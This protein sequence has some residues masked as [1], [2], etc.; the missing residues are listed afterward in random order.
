MLIST[1]DIVPIPLAYPSPT[2]TVFST[3]GE[4][5]SAKRI[6]ADLNAEATNAEKASQRLQR[7][8]LDVKHLLKPEDLPQYKFKIPSR[9]ASRFSTQSDGQATAATPLPKPKL[10]AF[11]EMVLNNTDVSYHYPSPVSG[12]SDSDSP[13]RTSSS[14]S[15]QKPHTPQAAPGAAPQAS[16]S[17]TLVSHGQYAQTLQPSP[18][19]RKIIKTP[20]V[21]IPRG[22]NATER[23]QYQ[24]YPEVALPY[25]ADAESPSKKR[26]KDTT[27][28]TE[29]ELRASV[30]QNQKANAALTKLST[31]LADIFEAEDQLQPDTS[32]LVSQNTATIFVSD[33][34]ENPVLRP[35]I[36]SQLDTLLK[37][38]AA[39]Q[40][41]GNVE[42][43][44]LSRIQKLCLNAV[45]PAATVSLGVG[46]DWSDS[47]VE[48]WCHRLTIAE[49]G[50]HACTSLLRVMTAGRQEKELYSE[51]MLRT[52]VEMITHVVDTCI[53]PI[54]EMRSTSE[55]FKQASSQSKI[56]SSIFSSMTKVLKLL[57]GLFA[58]MD[59][60]ESAVTSSEFICKTLL[61]GETPTSEKDSVVAGQ[62]FEPV[63]RAAMDVMARIF[64]RYTDQRQFIF[65]EIL[66]SLE[67]LPV[68][69]Q[70][71]RLFKLI[72]SKPIQPASALLMRLVQTSAVYTPA[73]NAAKSYGGARDGEEGSG[74]DADSDSEDDKRYIP[75][76]KGPSAPNASNEDLGTIA[77]PLQQAAQKNAQY[78]VQYLVG[79][80]LTSKKSGDE[81]Y[82]NLLDIFT[83]DFLT[84]LG[85]P[86]WPAAELLLRALFLK[87]S[88]IVDSKQNTVPAKVMALELLGAIASGIMDLQ[89]HAQRLGQAAGK[90]HSDVTARLV[91]L[92]D[93]ILTGDVSE[94]DLLGFEGPYR[95]V[96]EYLDR[97]DTNAADAHLRTAR[98]YHTM[99]WAVEAVPKRA[100]S[101]NS[102][103]DKLDKSLE[104]C[105]SKM[106]RDPRWLETEYDFAQV[107]PEDGRLAS[108]LIT[109]HP[110]MSYVLR[111]VFTRLVQT[112]TDEQASIRSKSLKSVEHL[113][114]KD[115]A[116]LDR[117]ASILTAITRST[118]DTSPRVRDSAYGL[119]AK[120]LSLRPSLDLRVYEALAARADD[121]NVGIRK[122]LMKMLKEI[123]ARNSTEQVRTRVAEALIH[124]IA[125]VEESV[126]D[127][128]RQSFEE[129]WIT[130]LTAMLGSSG[131]PILLKMQLRQQTSF[132]ITT[133]QKYASVGPVLR[134]LLQEILSKNPKTAELN[135]TVCNQM[136]A[137]L[138]EAV[139][140][141]NELPGAPAQAAVL[142]TLA[143]FASANPKLVVADQLQILLPYVKNLTSNDSLHVFRFAVMILRHTLPNVTNV[144]PKFASDIQ[145]AL[146][147]SFQKLPKSELEEV[148]CCLW[149]LNGIVGNP[150]RLVRTLASV[151]ANIQAKHGQDLNKDPKVAHQ[152]QRL[153]VI[154][155]CFVKE[156]DLEDHVADF[157]AKF[158]KFKGNSV[159]SCA[160]TAL[161]PLTVPRQPAIVRDAALEALCMI[162]QAWPKEYMRS[163][164]VNAI[165]LGFRDNEPRLDLI[166]LQGLGEFYAS[167]EKP[168]GAG[169][170]VQVGTGIEAG[171]E[172]LGKTYEATGRD[173]ALT[174]IAQRFL[175]HILRSALSS[176]DDIAL[177]AARLITSISRQ[178]LIYPNDC[179]PCLIALITS[180]NDLVAKTALVE[181]Q[182][183]NTKYESMFEK[184]HMRAV[185]QAYDYQR[186]AIHDSHGFKGTPPTPK[187]QPF[188]EVLKIGSVR[189]RKRFLES[190]YSRMDFEPGKLDIAGQIPDHVGFTRFCNENIAFFD[191]PRHDELQN[192]VNVI[193]RK[194]TATGSS[195]AHA[196]ES[197]ILKV[198]LEPE[199]Y[200]TGMMQNG[201]MTDTVPGMANGFTPQPTMQLQPPQDP[202][203]EAAR[204]REL[205]IYAQ[206]LF[207]QWETRTYLRRL[208]NLSKA[209]TA[210]SKA[211]PKDANRAPTRIPNS[212]NLTERYL[213]RNREIVDA[214]ATPESQHKLCAAFA[215]LMAV[216][217]E[218]KIADEDADADVDLAAGYETP[219][220]SQS[221]KS[222]SQ[223]ASG[224]GGKG[225]KRKS[226]TP[227][228]TPSKKKRVATG[229]RISSFSQGDEEAWD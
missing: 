107:S 88:D 53:V 227:A 178:G 215:E 47:D 49:Q 206:V 135:T 99:R 87:F 222:G 45:A 15:A 158:P 211:N 204:L 168:K 98:G 171:T 29:E 38:A 108:A 90:D 172:R 139:I 62:K 160:V 52:L 31:L 77:I 28:V 166:L 224:G 114:E 124:R 102:E 202:E 80:A 146:F 228:G 54:I 70:S 174:S 199:A 3:D 1:P 2:S 22:L 216:D 111:T 155:G 209:P 42:A 161:C 121:P 130:P 137:L 147:A 103:A 141:S 207:L 218:V 214:L 182:A 123:Y 212:T 170:E 55:G 201:M 106:I 151:L 18:L 69:R 219:S 104:S 150:E 21:I 79:R 143:I 67:K 197:D 221:V 8:L 32:G 184:E 92:H 148:A 181:L 136:V 183:L 16:S 188:W 154:A 58:S 19:D 35:E 17:A 51:D 61:F 164:V 60:D 229:K 68:G 127:L 41:L 142:E 94:T 12:T 34:I 85:H 198:R 163:D 73:E 110:Q 24:S 112:M 113:L 81:P 9:I 217:H 200:Q 176:N 100:V 208:W 191:Y 117:Q 165:T 144:Q 189:A 74:P 180:P 33:D 64:A 186:D 36:Q 125:D 115:P 145:D 225:R 129:L 175:Q 105:L 122:R 205:A 190:I 210:K 83:E 75:K 57:G 203:K 43:D 126:A 196:I 134:D 65:D 193:E 120:C 27:T 37:K 153:I 71:A 46:I 133:V 131:N 6:L 179:G 97:L 223:P 78:I 96:L 25:S 119:M 23:A 152:T 93:A 63:R 14:R 39:A 26:S 116:I 169:D 82:R 20:A 66:M 149:T 11:A 187:L 48:E 84:V 13:P 132:I 95:V 40:C 213:A 128:A 194:V 159:A 56:L 30:D 195:V 140:D 220:E 157:R 76:R 91:Q 5:T 59:V 192:L 50:L 101:V 162:C 118:S 86:D 173:G 89:L 44:H 185:K 138:F 226:M 10:G 177:A 156:F 7:T 4:R 167:N 109:L 72:D